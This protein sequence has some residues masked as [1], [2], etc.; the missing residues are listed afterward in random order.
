MCVHIHVRTCARINLTYFNIRLKNSRCIFGSFER[1]KLRARVERANFKLT[2]K[3]IK[4]NN[5][6]LTIFDAPSR[7]FV[8][9]VSS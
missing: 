2:A 8:R 3:R 9:V 4:K 6:H 5:V 7:I 1:R